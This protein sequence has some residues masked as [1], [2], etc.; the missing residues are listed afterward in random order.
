MTAL[1]RRIIALPRVKQLHPIISYRL[2]AKKTASKDK[3][4]STES[5]ITKSIKSKFAQQKIDKEKSLYTYQTRQRIQNPSGYQHV[6]RQLRR[7]DENQVMQIM[8]NNKKCEDVQVGTA[9][10]KAVKLLFED[11]K[12]PAYTALKHINEIWSIMNQYVVGMDCAAYNEYFHA[13]G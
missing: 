8:R 13:C 11:N 5:D 4:E 2:F 9:A 3:T 10:I 7:C 6:K 12:V 1:L